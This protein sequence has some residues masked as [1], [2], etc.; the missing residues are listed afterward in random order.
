MSQFISSADN[1]EDDVVSHCGR[2]L[3]SD[4]MNALWM[5]MVLTSSMLP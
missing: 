4:V 5:T 2:L 3:P 1:L